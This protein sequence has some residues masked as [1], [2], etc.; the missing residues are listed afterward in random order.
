[1]FWSKLSPAWMTRL[2]KCLFTNWA[3]HMVNARCVVRHLPER[4]V[5]GYM[6]CYISKCFWLFILF[7]PFIDLVHTCCGLFC[8]WKRL[9]LLNKYKVQVGNFNFVSIL[10]S[11]SKCLDFIV[12]AQSKR[13]LVELVHC[14]KADTKQKQMKHNWWN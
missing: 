7:F 13:K 8:L 9:K 3:L 10:K 2:R 1:M 5:V 4:V 12:P 6:C 14:S 11:K